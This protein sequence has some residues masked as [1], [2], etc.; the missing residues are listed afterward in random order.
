MD[1]SIIVAI[2][3]GTISSWLPVLVFSVKNPASKAKLKKSTPALRALA[4][5]LLN[6]CDTVDNLTAKK[7]LKAK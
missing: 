3:S 5:Q 2:I 7:A 4:A 1:P 6:F